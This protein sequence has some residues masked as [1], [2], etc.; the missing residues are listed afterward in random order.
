MAATALPFFILFAIG[1]PLID[2]PSRDG[3]QEED[4]RQPRRDVAIEIRDDVRREF[5]GSRETD[6]PKRQG[7]RENA[8][9]VMDEHG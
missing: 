3:K 5:K 4:D 1:K 6:A 7:A 2:Y 9:P 8:P